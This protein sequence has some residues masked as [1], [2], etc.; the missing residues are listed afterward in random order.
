MVAGQVGGG[1]SALQRQLLRQVGEGEQGDA[2]R[3]QLLH[4]LQGGVEALGGL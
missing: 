3:A 4:Q 2:I 1:D